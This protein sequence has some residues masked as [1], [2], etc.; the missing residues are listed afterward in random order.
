PG[1]WKRSGSEPKAWVRAFEVRVGRA[2]CRAGSSSRRT[3]M[4]GVRLDKWLWA[5][6]F[7]K[8]RGLSSEEIGRGRVSVNGQP[9]KSSREVKVGDSIALRQNQIPRTVVVR[10]TS[11]V[12]GPAPV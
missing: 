10:G 7:F 2:A 6:R 4:T 12:R 9:A 8:T 5:A 3:W 11:D 1:S